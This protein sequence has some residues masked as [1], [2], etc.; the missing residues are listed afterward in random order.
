MTKYT[1]QEQALIKS[2]VAMLSIKKAHDND[3]INEF[4]N[5]TKKTIA[6]KT[7]CNIRQ[8]IKK[9]SYH[10]YNALRE[11][12]YEYIHSFKERDPMVTKKAS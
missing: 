12:Q 6:Q 1:T 9:D 5:Q 10:W 4:Y 7:L 2:I 3:I 8:Q 11:G